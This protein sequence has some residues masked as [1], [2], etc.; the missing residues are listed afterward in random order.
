MN[1]HTQ[2]QKTTTDN[3]QTQIKYK[4]QKQAGTPARPG[5][6]RRRAPV[7]RASGALGAGGLHAPV[8]LAASV[9]CL[10][11]GR[12]FATEVAQAQFAAAMCG[13][14]APFLQA[15]ALGSLRTLR[16]RLQLSGLSPGSPLRLAT[17]RRGLL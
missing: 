13:G 17:E 15:A 6:V 11:Y 1:K 12:L 9:V 5:A 4:H 16:I 7:G 2:K 8:P 3:N 10:A 14:W